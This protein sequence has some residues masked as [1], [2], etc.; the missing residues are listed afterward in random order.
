MW[1]IADLLNER[2]A[3]SVVA[4]TG[5]VRG[6]RELPL[7]T[8]DDVCKLV[9]TTATHRVASA[10]KCNDNSSRS[11]AIATLRL[12]RINKQDGTF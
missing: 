10:T 8:A 12:T 9:N 3:C 6:Y 7:K 5:E 2:K 1:E 4:E 11:H